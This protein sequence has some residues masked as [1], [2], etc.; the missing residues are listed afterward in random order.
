MYLG[1]KSNLEAYPQTGNIILDDNLNLNLNI[2]PTIC[3]MVIILHDKVSGK[4]N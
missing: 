1:C 2:I 3:Y 4:T